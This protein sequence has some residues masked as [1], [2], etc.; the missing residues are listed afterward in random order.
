MLSSSTTA[1]TSSNGDEKEI[2][3]L[4]LARALMKLGSASVE[5]NATRKNNS[6]PELVAVAVAAVVSLQVTTAATSL[7]QIGCF[8][9]SELKSELRSMRASRSLPALH[10]RKSARKC[11]QVSIMVRSRCQVQNWPE[12]ASECVASVRRRSVARSLDRK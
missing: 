3:F 2:R 9:C 4:C 11:F 6:L 8:G 5:L 12:R 7:T 10:S 1:T